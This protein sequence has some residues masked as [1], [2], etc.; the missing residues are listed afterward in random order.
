VDKAGIQDLVNRYSIETTAR[1]AERVER[2]SDFLPPATRL[3]IVHVPGTNLEGTVHLAARLRREGIE[4]VPHIVARRIESLSVLDDF[5]RRLAEEA[6]VKQVLVVGGDVAPAVGEIDSTLAVLESGL[7]EQ[8]EIRSIGVA[9]H[10]E[11]HPTI[12][13]KILRDALRRKNA[14]AQKTGAHV[15]IVTQF[16]FAHD[17][18]VSWEMSH[19]TDIGALPITVGLPGLATPTTLLRFAMDCGVGPSLQAFKKRAGRISRLLTVAT[20]DNIIV[21]LAGY[22]SAHTESRVAGVHF[23]PFGGLRRTAEWANAIVAGNFDILDED[24]LRVRMPAP[25]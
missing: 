6:G 1:E 19:G 14:Y 12:P 2:F 25:R 9:G 4:P 21:G 23:F 18:I 15:Y 5:L 8:N 7:L 3:Y 20:P 16:L 22:K 24:S 17:P 13:D 10:P 11:G